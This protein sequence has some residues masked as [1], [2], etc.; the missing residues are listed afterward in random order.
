MGR[1]PIKIENQRSN[2]KI[3][4]KI[5]WAETQSRS[6]IKDRTGKENPRSDGQRPNQD[7]EYKIEWEKKPKIAWAKTQSRSKI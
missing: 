3:K 7:R 1:D 4:P 5:G 2:G 6:E